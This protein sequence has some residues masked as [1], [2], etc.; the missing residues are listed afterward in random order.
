MI[1]ICWS[2]H[3]VMWEVQKKS[4]GFLISRLEHLRRMKDLLDMEE[5]NQSEKWGIKLKWIER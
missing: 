5:S 4:V 3:D 1:C 2:G